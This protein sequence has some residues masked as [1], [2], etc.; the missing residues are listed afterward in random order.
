[1][2]GDAIRHATGCRRRHAAL[3]LL[4]CGEVADPD[5][6]HDQKQ[7]SADRA[8]VDQRPGDV[9]RD[10]LAPGTSR[11]LNYAHAA[12]STPE[13][14]LFTRLRINGILYALNCKGTAPSTA[15]L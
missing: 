7:Q 2:P 14:A 12:T 5:R 3:I 4:G 11:P 1:M 13:I 10:I 8:H 6:V 9:N 15:I